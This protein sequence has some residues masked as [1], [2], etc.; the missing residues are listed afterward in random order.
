M[1]PFSSEEIRIEEEKARN[2]ERL[3]QFQHRQHELTG[4]WPAVYPANVR[5]P[6]PE[7]QA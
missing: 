6:R 5:L 3:I 2:I 1:K 4:C 7:S